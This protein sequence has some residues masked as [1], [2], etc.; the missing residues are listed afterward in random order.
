MSQRQKE[1]RK[2]ND[3]EAR[4]WTL[5]GEYMKALRKDRSLVHLGEKK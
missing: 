4:L 1:E 2:S 5:H 3:P